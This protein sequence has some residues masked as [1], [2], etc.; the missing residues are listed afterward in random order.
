MDM[1]RQSLPFLTHEPPLNLKTMRVIDIIRN[2][3]LVVLQSKE[4]K[5]E[6]QRKLMTCTHNG[7]PVIYDDAQHGDPEFMRSF[8][9]GT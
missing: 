8:E 5:S 2:K 4:K 7:F 1:Y 9:G 3:P 6:L